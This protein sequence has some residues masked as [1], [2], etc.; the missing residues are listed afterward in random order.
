MAL[1][2]HGVETVLKKVGV[3]PTGEAFNAIVLDEESVVP[4]ILWSTQVPLPRLI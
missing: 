2:D 4:L 1:E 3:E